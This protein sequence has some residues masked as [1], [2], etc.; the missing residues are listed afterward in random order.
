MASYVASSWLTTA[1]SWT[2][3]DFAAAGAGG[4][5][6][7]PWPPGELVLHVVGGDD[8]FLQR[9]L[10]SV[11]PYGEQQVGDVDLP[12]RHRRVAPRALPQVITAG[13]GGAAA[14]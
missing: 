10:P 3:D 9:S 11:L 5:P 13:V 2:L 1:S 12:S 6:A 4:G 14:R 7:I 8:P